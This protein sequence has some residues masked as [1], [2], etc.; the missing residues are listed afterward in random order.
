MVPAEEND[1][2]GAPVSSNAADVLPPRWPYDEGAGGGRVR[3]SRIVCAL[4]RAGC[5]IGAEQRLPCGGIAHALPPHCAGVLFATAAQ[6]G[7]RRAVRRTHSIVHRTD[8]GL[9]AGR[10]SCG[11]QPPLTDVIT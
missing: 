2:C 8:T 3:E 5:G 6:V 1:E 10:A 9:S 11:A 4:R 7:Q